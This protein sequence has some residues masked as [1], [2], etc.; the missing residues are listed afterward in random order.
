MP[1]TLLQCSAR[2]LPPGCIQEPAH[3]LPAAHL[4]Q[5]H[6]AQHQLRQL[7]LEAQAL[8]PVAQV[9]CA[10]EQ[11]LAAP[12]LTLPR[13]LLCRKLGQRAERLHVGEYGCRRCP[14]SRLPLRDFGQQG[15]K[16]ALAPAGQQVVR[17]GQPGGGGGAPVGAQ[18]PQEVIKADAARI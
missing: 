6:V 15:L 11:F 12:P 17:R 10:H 16:V 18:R 9:G 3:V 8:R 13:R 4:D 2:W 1:S 5:R 14:W 7:L